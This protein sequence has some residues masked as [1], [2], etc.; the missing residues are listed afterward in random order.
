MVARFMKSLNNVI[1]KSIEKSSISYLNKHQSLTVILKDKLQVCASGRVC[2]YSLLS[3][4]RVEKNTYMMMV[5][6]KSNA[7]P[8]RLIANKK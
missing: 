3:F 6:I 5:Q 7:T 4:Y 2:E 8:T 1:F